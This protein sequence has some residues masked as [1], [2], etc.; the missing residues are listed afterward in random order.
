MDVCW[1]SRWCRYVDHLDVEIYSMVCGKMVITMCMSL[2]IV[3][4]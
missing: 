3:L 1:L 4:S 2:C